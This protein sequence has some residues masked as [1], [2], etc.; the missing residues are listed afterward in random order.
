MATRI[1]ERSFSETA[2]KPKAVVFGIG[3]E[4]GRTVDSPSRGYV[5]YVGPSSARQFASI[6]YNTVKSE[7]ASPHPVFIFVV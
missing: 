4:P 2:P 7:R 3:P 1:S 6:N 5:G